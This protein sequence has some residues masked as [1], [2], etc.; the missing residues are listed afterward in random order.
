MSKKYISFSPYIAGLSNVIMSY[1]LFT[2]IA[3]IT[4]RKVILPPKTCITGI[5]NSDSEQDYNDIWDIFD[6]ETYTKYFDCIN[7]YDVPEFSENYESIKGP[8]P[9]YNTLT[10]YT[11]NIDDVINDVKKI[12]FGPQNL[13]YLDYS[14]SSISD[15]KCDYVLTCNT[16]YSD[17][18]KNF[19]SGRKILDLNYSNKFLHFENNLFGH[20]WYNVYPGQSEERNRLKKI[21]NKV[22]KYKEKYYNI[23]NIVKEK[24]GKYNAVHIRRDDFLTYHDDSLDVISDSEKILKVLDILFDEKKYPLYIATD[25]KN[26]DFFHDLINK[27]EIYFF[28]DFNFNLNELG[29]AV[30]EQII[31]SQSEKFYGTKYST[32]T[33]RINIMRGCEKRQYNDSIFLNDLEYYYNNNIN[34]HDQFPWKNKEKC[35]WEWSDSSHL[36]WKIEDNGVLKNCKFY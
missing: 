24:I 2:S 7:F 4:K 5:S 27:Y 14:E 28:S 26:L 10:S 35:R 29:T 19:S 11:A 18:L 9:V 32:F 1:E 36:Q 25:E 20:Y 8:I 34:L 31:C 17:D 3:H 33:K 23:S 16:K 13:C 22:F 21:I 15:C 30:A 12:N 6:L